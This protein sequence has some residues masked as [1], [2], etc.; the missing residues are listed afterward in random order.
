MSSIL[1][2]ST[3]FPFRRNDGRPVGCPIA[4]CA[5][6]RAV[7]AFAAIGRGVQKTA[8]AGLQQNHARFSMFSLIALYLTYRR[9]PVASTAA[10][11]APVPVRA[12][13]DTHAVSAARAA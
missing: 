8:C 10:T 3:I 13:N 9:Q 12:G 11:V 1:T 6:A 5:F 4:F 2:G 7:L